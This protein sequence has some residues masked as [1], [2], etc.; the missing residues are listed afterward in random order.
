MKSAP[1]E[2]GAGRASQLRASGQQLL[3]ILEQVRPALAPVLLDDE[4]YARLAT[5]A[6]LLPLELSS[7]WGFEF[8]LGERQP[9]ADILFET[10]KGSLGHQLLAGNSPSS[11]DQ[12]CQAFSGW[13]T[14]RT[15]AG[16]WLQP[17]HPCH[18]L[19]RNLW[20]E[21][22]LAE[23]TSPQDL[24]HALR[25][26]NFFFGPEPQ[27][28][29]RELLALIC[30]VMRLHG[31]TSPAPARIAWFLE[32]LP[33]GA[34]LFQVG[35]MLTR[36]EDCGLRLC[37]K[38]VPSETLHPWLHRLLP[39]AEAQAQ[40]EL[41]CTLLPLAEATALGFNL[42]AEGVSPAIGLECYQ[43]WLQDDPAQWRPLLDYLSAR[44]VCLPEKGAGVQGY[45]G[46]T[47]SP[48]E[49]RMSGNQLYLNTYRKIH[50]LKCTLAA[51]RIAQ[52]KAYLAVSRPGVPLTNFLCASSPDGQRTKPIW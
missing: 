6:A 28:T 37:V 36:E 32:N 20:L 8:R 31:R 27:A 34:K 4:G 11:L 16:Y 15:F 2:T 48:L 50:H 25:E 45:A 12:L 41:A 22:D 26:P 5:V 33:A 18:R 9:R 38:E 23:A 3:S 52:A 35:L 13:R 7:F 10:L 24:D 29:S 1:A 46:V 14:L 47:T 49:E 42:T 19:A 39:S 17:D 51:G 44:A 43:D 40:A 30:E 21:F